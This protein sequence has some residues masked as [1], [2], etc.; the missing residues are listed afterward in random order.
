MSSVPPFHSRWIENY[1]NLRT[2]N[3]RKPADPNVILLLAVYKCVHI[4]YYYTRTKVKVNWKE[5]QPE[6]VLSTS[7]ANA[8]SAGTAETLW[9]TLCIPGRV[10][11]LF[12]VL[13]RSCLG[14]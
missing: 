11:Q 9:R 12:L 5:A 1:F 10:S 8:H 4:H 13:V 3:D 14:T 6:A 7:D 2:T